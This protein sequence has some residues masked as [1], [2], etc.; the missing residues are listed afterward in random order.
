MSAP[1][2]HVALRGRTTIL[3]SGDIIATSGKGEAFFP[4]ICFYC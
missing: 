1:P 2:V 3:Q 4:L